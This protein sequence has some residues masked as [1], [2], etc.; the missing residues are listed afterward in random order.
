MVR[1]LLL[2]VLRV[3]DNRLGKIGGFPK[4]P[5]YFPP[6]FHG[7]ARAVAPYARGRIIIQWGNIISVG[8]KKGVNPGRCNHPV[9]YYEL[10]NTQEVLLII[11]GKYG[12][13]V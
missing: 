4:L 10:G 7:G 12:V 11:L 6:Y 5:G 8:Y 9:I 3:R 13:R 2:N 1:V